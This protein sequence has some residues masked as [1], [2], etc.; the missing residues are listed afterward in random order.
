MCKIVEWFMSQ[1]KINNYVLK[2]WY[3]QSIN[4]LNEKVAD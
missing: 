1:E 4:K 2:T 3:N